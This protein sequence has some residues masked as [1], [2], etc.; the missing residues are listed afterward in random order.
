M[1][2]RL[3]CPLRWVLQ[4]DDLS[5][6]GSHVGE[7]HPGPDQRQADQRHRQALDLERPDVEEDEAGEGL[8]TAEPMMIARYT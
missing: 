5:P 4:A 3:L 8:P 2:K 7:Q 6:L 1:A